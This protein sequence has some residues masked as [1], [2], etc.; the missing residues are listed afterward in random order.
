MELMKKLGVRTIGIGVETINPRTK[1]TQ[2]KIKKYL[3]IESVRKAI[4]LTRKYRIKNHVSFQAGLPGETEKT[5]I[6]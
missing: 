1:R 5:L 3:N 6:L 2:R 4:S